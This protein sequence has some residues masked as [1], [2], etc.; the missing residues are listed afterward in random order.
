MNRKNLSF[1]NQEIANELIILRKNWPLTQEK[2]GR[3]LHK[4][5][6]YVSKVELGIRQ[7]SFIELCEY[8][9]KLEVDVKV[10]I[11]NLSF[12]KK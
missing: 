2:L 8:L 7:L 3:K 5:Q 6:S 9:N 11:S 12:I 4:P 1:Y 10:F